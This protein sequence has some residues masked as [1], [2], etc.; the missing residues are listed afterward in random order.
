MISESLEQRIYRF[1]IE[2]SKWLASA[3]LPDGTYLNEP[4]LEVILDHTIGQLLQLTTNMAKGETTNESRTVKET[5]TVHTFAS[6]WDHLKY[7]LRSIRLVPK[8]VK[9]RISVR[10]KPVE[11]TFN[12]GLQVAVTRSCPHVDFGKD[13]LK[14]VA[15]LYPTEWKKQG[16][17]VPPSIQNTTACLG[18]APGLPVCGYGCPRLAYGSGSM[19]GYGGFKA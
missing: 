14:H 6:W 9:D 18:C 12:F 11:Y 15:F 5:R 4:N 1:T 16:L 13:P 17:P 7:D 3:T 19:P 2:K 8:L 10:Y